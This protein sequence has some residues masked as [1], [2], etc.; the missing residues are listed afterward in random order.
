MPLCQ[1]SH[2]LAST[3][4]AGNYVHRTTLARHMKR[5][6][7][8]QDLENVY[9]S[10]H[11]EDSEDKNLHEG[12]N[13]REEESLHEEHKRSPMEICDNEEHERSSMEICDNEEISMEENLTNND[14]S[15]FQNDE[16]EGTNDCYE[17]DDSQSELE[18]DDVNS[19]ADGEEGEF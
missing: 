12:E 19:N 2:C 9:Q 16:N 17:N 7:T 10:L 3:N 14:N 6:K 5:E 18:S 13:L 11:S 1:C 15:S 8:E 4:G